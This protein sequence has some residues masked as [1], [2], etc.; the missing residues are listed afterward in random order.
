M[1]EVFFSGFF[2]SFSFRP[3]S[4]KTS[5]AV[6]KSVGPGF[7]TRK[8]LPCPRKKT[9]SNQIAAKSQWIGS[10]TGRRGRLLLN[11]ARQS[12]KRLPTKK[13]SFFFSLTFFRKKLKKQNFLQNPRLRP[14]PDGRRPHPGP[15]G[16]H[17]RRLRAQHP[18]GSKEMRPTST[19]H[20]SLRLHRCWDTDAA[21]VLRRSGAGARGAGMHL[22]ARCPPPRGSPL[23]S[24]CAAARG[25]SAPRPCSHTRHAAVAR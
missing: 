23:R 16:R 1:S 8:F 19:V 7:S 15:V 13:N 6:S 14:Q 9:E 17:R 2:F 11:F 3:P 20:W 5:K 12:M 21:A 22:C 24:P 10:R 25:A 18:S 4:K